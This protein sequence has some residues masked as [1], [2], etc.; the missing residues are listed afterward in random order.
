LP[1]YP[2]ADGAAKDQKHQSYACGQHPS[3]VNNIRM[4]NFFLNCWRSCSK[5]TLNRLQSPGRNTIHVVIA[6]AES[7]ELIAKD[8]LAFKSPIFGQGFSQMVLQ[9]YMVVKVGF[10]EVD[11]EESLDKAKV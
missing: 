8:T 11:V 9:L 2:S 4:I 3:G 7:S 1:A 5:Y 10:S 6:F